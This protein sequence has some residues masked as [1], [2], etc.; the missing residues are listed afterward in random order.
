MML[1]LQLLIIDDHEQNV[2]AGVA[3]KMKSKKKRGRGCGNKRAFK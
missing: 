2:S 1:K 3:L